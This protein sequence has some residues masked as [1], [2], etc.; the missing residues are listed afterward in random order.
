M[1]KLNPDK[2][3]IITY[4]SLISA[5]EMVL[6]KVCK[7]LEHAYDPKMIATEGVYDDLLEQKKKDLDPNFLRRLKS[8]HSGL[9]QKP[10]SNKIGQ[11]KNVLDSKIIN[12]IE[13]I[14]GENLEKFGYETK[15][16][17]VRRSTFK[18]MYF[19]L[20][21]KCYRR[22]LLTVYLNIPL[23]LKLKIKIFRSKKSVV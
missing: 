8:F 2:R 1:K 11:Y 13:S 23:W 7:W 12:E 6:T 19:T 20:L 16:K 17:G 15:N 4:E 10:N 5:P 21:A 18:M 22:Y 9:S 14:C 3:I